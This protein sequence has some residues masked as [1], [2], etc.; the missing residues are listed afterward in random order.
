[1]SSV[2]SI[3]NNRNIGNNSLIKQFMKGV[4]NKKPCITRLGSTWAVSDVLNRFVFKVVVLQ[5]SLVM[6]KPVF[7]VSDLVRH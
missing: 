6:R 1:M 5:L 2:V 4:F 7:G 3:V